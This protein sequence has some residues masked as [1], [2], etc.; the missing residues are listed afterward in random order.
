[1]IAAALIQFSRL[2]QGAG[3]EATMCRYKNWT[4]GAN[5]KTEVAYESQNSFPFGSLRDLD[6]DSSGVRS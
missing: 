1:V 6:D 3:S 5:P 4:S 2:P